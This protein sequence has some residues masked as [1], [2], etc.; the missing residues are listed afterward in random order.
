MCCSPVM[1][2]PALNLARFWS[3]GVIFTGY[4]PSPAGWL[5]YCA[6]SVFGGEQCNRSEAA[7]FD[8]CRIDLKMR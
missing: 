4:A 3:D 7:T 8:L 5:F 6:W 1:T 2:F